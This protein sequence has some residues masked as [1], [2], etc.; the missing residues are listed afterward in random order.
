M[1]ALLVIIA[2]VVLLNIIGLITNKVISRNELQGIK[3]YGKLVDVNGKRI[4]VYAKGEYGNGKETIVLLPGLNVILPSADFDPLMCE[5]SDNYNVVSV[6]YFG[7]GFSDKTETPRTNENYVDEIRQALTATGFYPPYILMPYSASG[8]YSEFYATKYPDELKALILLDTT[9]SAE[10]EMAMPPRFVFNITK[11]QQATGFT[12]IINP[13]LLPKIV[14]LTAENGYTEKH[15]KD[16]LKFASHVNND[17]LIDQNVRFP[18]NV[19]EVMGLDFP[20]KVPVLVIR[21]DT[22]SNGKWPNYVNIHLKKLGDHAKREV[23]KGSTHTSIYHNR[24]HRK[25]VCEAV[26]TFINTIG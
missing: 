21:A 6:E 15:I 18:D 3:P 13:L 7:Y 10:K 9:S 20:T 11:L 26:E 1:T 23:I 16:I 14:G 24:K 25:A 19:L 5:L 22:Y 2:I 12:R 17:T 4:H 8:I